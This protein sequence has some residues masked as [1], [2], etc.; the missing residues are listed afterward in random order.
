MA[1]G[2]IEF[3][4]GALSFSGEGELE[5]LAS[6]LDKVLE[7]AP[8]LQKIVPA[9][10]PAAPPSPPGSGTGGGFTDTLASYVKAK[11]AD[12]NQVKRFLATADWLRRRGTPTLT[13]AAVSKALSDHHQKK[14]SNPADCLNKNVAKGHCEKKGEGFFITP[15]GLTE[16]GN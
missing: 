5:W 2:K 6:Q 11:G 7:A 14:L 16:L 8:S 13:T 10:Q 1:E 4:L 3:S 15:D 9:P 12:S